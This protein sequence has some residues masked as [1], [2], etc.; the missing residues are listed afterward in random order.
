MS[1]W[2]SRNGQDTANAI[3]QI[4]RELKKIRE[5]MEKEAH[6]IVASP[7]LFNAPVEKAIKPLIGAGAMGLATLGEVLSTDES[8]EE[9][10][11]AI[12]KAKSA[13]LGNFTQHI[14]PIMQ[15]GEMHTIYDSSDSPQRQGN[16]LGIVTRGIDGWLIEDAMVRMGPHG[17]DRKSLSKNRAALAAALASELNVSH[18]AKPEPHEKHKNAIKMYFKLLGSAV[19]GVQEYFLGY[20]AADVADFVMNTPFGDQHTWK[21]GAKLDVLSY[22]SI[23]ARGLR[24]NLLIMDVHKRDEARNWVNEMESALFEDRVEE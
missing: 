22:V 11:R 13:A 3:I 7:C 5:L 9:T 2:E 10:R 12:E 8:K 1:F 4:P 15:F 14:A 21:D 19:D 17:D 18:V 23:G 20:L 24:A 16:R 6:P